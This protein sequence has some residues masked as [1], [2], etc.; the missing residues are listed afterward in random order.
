[1][2]VHEED[3]EEG[4]DCREAFLVEQ[5]E[6]GQY[7]DAGYFDRSAVHHAV[8]QVIEEI[9]KIAAHGHHDE[10]VQ[11]PEAGLWGMGRG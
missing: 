4:R 1:M 9:D 10:R 6:D 5:D 8:G 2:Q 3:A 11:P 7:K